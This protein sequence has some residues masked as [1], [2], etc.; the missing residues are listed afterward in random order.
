MS[1]PHEREEISLSPLAIGYIWSTRIIS[2]SIEMGLIIL[3]FHWLDRKLGTAPLFVIA[4][5]LI[6]IAVFFIQITALAKK[7]LTSAAGEP[8]EETKPN[9]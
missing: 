1:G 5:S 4:G 7:P 9:A 6:A 8:E 2:L 3:A